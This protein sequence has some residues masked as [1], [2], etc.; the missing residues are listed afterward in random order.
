[1]GLVL[2]QTA[3]RGAQLHKDLYQGEHD[4][5]GVTLGGHSLWRGMM[6]R[7][8]TKA[9]HDVRFLLCPPTAPQVATRG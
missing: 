5:G 6:V 9:W 2:G 8:Y 3:L 1:M 4:D 7:A